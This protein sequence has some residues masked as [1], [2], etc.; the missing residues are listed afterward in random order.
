MFRT[1]DEMEE[2]EQID[3]TEDTRENEDCADGDIGNGTNTKTKTKTKIKIRLPKNKLFRLLHRTSL[4]NKA[5]I[6]SSAPLPKMPQRE[7][8]FEAPHVDRPLPKRPSRV[9]SLED[10]GGG[11]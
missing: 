2:L 8:S 7:T 11:I 4:A 3:I 10:L 1:I 9:Q 5:F 6:K